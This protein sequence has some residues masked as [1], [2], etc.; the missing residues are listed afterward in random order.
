MLE[1]PSSSITHGLQIK[2][3]RRQIK[4]QRGGRH[5]SS[6]LCLDD[7]ANKGNHSK[8]P[9]LNLLGLHLLHTQQAS[10]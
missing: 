4:V 7:E 9:V 8:P 5:L 10:L 2:M 3:D 1:M 6:G